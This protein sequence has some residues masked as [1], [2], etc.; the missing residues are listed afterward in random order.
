MLSYVFNQINNFIVGFDRNRCNWPTNKK[1]ETPRPRGQKFENPRRKETRLRDF[2]IGT[3][4]SETLS[5]PGT[6]H[7]PLKSHRSSANETLRPSLR[8]TSSTGDE[9]AHY[10]ALRKTFAYV[11]GGGSSRGV[12]W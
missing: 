12:I 3:K 6:I 5:F 7:H 1:S 4:I 2:E 11:R 10:C 9:N 8:I